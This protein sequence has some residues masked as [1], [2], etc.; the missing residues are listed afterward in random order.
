MMTAVA[1]VFF[2]MIAVA[3]VFCDAV[4]RQRFCLS[5]LV[6]LFILSCYATDAKFYAMLFLLLRSINYDEKD[7]FLCNTCGFYKYGKF[8][9]TL[10]ARP[11]SAV[12][13]IESEEDRTKVRCL[14]V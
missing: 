9:M 6:C 7:P 13:P 11:C 2:V 4:L 12:D 1:G 10:T 5:T 8:D 14:L 3:G